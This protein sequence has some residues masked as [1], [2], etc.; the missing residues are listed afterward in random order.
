M[1][2]AAQNVE[3]EARIRPAIPADGR[4]LAELIELASG[5]ISSWLWSQ[6]AGPGESPMEVG[7][8]RAGREEGGFS[9]R[10]ALVAEVEGRVAGMIL[11][12]RLPDAGEGEADPLAPD[13]LAGVPALLRPYIDLELQVPGSYYINAFALYEGYRGRGIGARLLQAVLAKAEEFGCRAVSVQTFSENTRAAAFYRRHGFRDRDS[14]PVI[15][16]PA[17]RY[18]GSTLLFVRDL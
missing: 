17:F 10:H 6:M 7:A 5:G 4:H 16:H 13:P 2:E 9:Y 11:A 8:R 14:R 1:S 18:R 3:Q 15:P 12:Y